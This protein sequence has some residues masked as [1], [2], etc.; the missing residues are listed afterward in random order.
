MMNIFTL[1]SVV[2]EILSLKA[3]QR[4]IISSPDVGMH[5]NSLISIGKMMQHCV[6]QMLN[7]LLPYFFNPNILF[8]MN[9]IYDGFDKKHRMGWG[10]RTI[11][12]NLASFHITCKTVCIF[13]KLVHLR[14]E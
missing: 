8:T 14:S 11:A 13:F 7:S 6:F 2:G 12:L 4:L 3:N 9:Q 10:F 1:E 5:L